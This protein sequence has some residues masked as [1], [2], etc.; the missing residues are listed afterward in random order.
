MSDAGTETELYRR[1]AAIGIVPVVQLPWSELAVPLAATLAAAGL[2]CLEVTF[3]AEGAAQAIADI[4]A[5]QPDVLVGAGTVL[6]IE[7]ADTAIESGAQFIVSPGTN[8][9]VVEHVLERGAPM[10][11]GVATPSEI[12]ANLERGLTLLKFF[13]AE[14]LGG[15]AFLR[16][17][18]G[19]FEA[20]RFIPSG[21][22]TPDNLAS[23]LVLGNVPAVGGTWIAPLSA[24]ESADFAAIERRARE[25]TNLV[26]DARGAAGGAG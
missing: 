14:P 2:P 17:V 23:Y 16:S 19:P 13:P 22:I 12:E 11:P 20:A 15:P 26:G 1:I 25:A 8:P 10:I 6:T 18:R 4:R 24:L 3:R 7:Q 5:A 9:R 21:G